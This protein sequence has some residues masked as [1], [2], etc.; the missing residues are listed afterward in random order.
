MDQPIFDS[1]RIRSTYGVLD[2]NPG[3]IT[4]AGFKF[5]CLQ[6]GVG[7]SVCVKER[8]SLVG[9]FKP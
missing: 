2:R 6:H 8:E 3:D 9:V 1:F 5:R 4:V 7:P